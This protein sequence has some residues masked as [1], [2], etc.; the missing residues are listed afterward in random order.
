MDPVILTII[1]SGFLLLAGGVFLFLFRFFHGKHITRKAETMARAGKDQEALFEYKLLQK[2]APENPKV[3]WG[4]ANAYLRTL[5]F[6]PGLEVLNRILLKN[7]VPEGLERTDIMAAA[8]R[9]PIP[10]RPD[11]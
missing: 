3:L 10:I 1:I 9:A 6:K 5:H 4:L 8:A 11:R 7:I 2:K